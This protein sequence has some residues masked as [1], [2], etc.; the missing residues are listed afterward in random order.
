MGLHQPG[1]ESHGVNSESYTAV[2]SESCHGTVRCLTVLIVHLILYF[3]DAD[4]RDRWLCYGDLLDNGAA[5]TG[6]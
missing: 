4:T 2:N 3:G 1:S 5:T 6:H